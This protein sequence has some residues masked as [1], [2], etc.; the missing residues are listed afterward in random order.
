MYRHTKATKIDQR[1]ELSTVAPA[2][3]T[4]AGDGDALVADVHVGDGTVVE[5]LT[6][7][8]PIIVEC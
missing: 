6:E 2:L 5:T 7:E 8:Y 3:P 4:R 1:N